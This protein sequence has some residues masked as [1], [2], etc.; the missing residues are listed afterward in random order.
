MKLKYFNATDTA[1]VEF[2]DNVV[3]ETITC[4]YVLKYGT[5]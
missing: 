2:T 1:L 3:Q 4:N 5:L